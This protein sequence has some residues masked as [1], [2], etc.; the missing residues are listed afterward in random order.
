M[1]YSISTRHSGC[2]VAFIQ[3]NRTY[4][5]FPVPRSP[6]PFPTPLVQPLLPSHCEYN[7]MD[8][9]YDPLYRLAWGKAL[10]GGGGNEKRETGNGERGTENR[11]PK[12]SPKPKSGNGMC[13]WWLYHSEQH[14][15]LLQ[16]VWNINSP[17]HIDPPHYEVRCNVVSVAM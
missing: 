8:Q 14:A 6:F 7:V 16:R 17:R 9:R 4:T 10:G 13:S 3:E 15:L 11:K 5:R 2:S 1:Y 12:K